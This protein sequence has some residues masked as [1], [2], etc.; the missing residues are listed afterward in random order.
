MFD[1]SKR[2]LK[3]RKTRGF[4]QI[5]L[6]EK[7]QISSSTLGNYE[8]DMIIP[9]LSVAESL[10]DG[11]NVSLDYLACGKKANTI[12][13]KSLKEEQIELVTELVR[14]F[15]RPANHSPKLIK[16]Q[17]ELLERIIEQFVQ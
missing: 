1:F 7:V 8:N 9:S 13:V 16:Q 5:E 4:S 10:A 6:A 14:E 3:L 11:L 15:A 17:Q 2:L 12:S